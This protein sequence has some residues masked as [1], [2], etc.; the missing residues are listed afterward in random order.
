VLVIGSSINDVDASGEE[1]MRELTSRLNENGITMVVSSMK[2]Q[3]QDVCKRS[4]L[5]DVVG[6]ENMFKTKEQAIE[7]LYQRFR[8]RGRAA[9]QA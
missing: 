6:E 3:V 1:K 8:N 4:G 5:C 7:A 9:A 2:K